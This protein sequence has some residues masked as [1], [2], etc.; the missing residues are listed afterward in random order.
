ME[1]RHDF[2]WRVHAQIPPRGVI[3][4]FNRSHYEDVLSP[5]VHHLI[6]K[7]VV[8][9]RLDRINDFED[10][11]VE[12]GVVILKF[13]LHISR[14]EQ[15]ERLQARIDTPD[16]HWKLS[17]ADFKERR[18]WPQYQNAY[19]EILSKTS[20]KHAPWFIIP[21]DHKW[22]RNIAISGIVLDVMKGLKLSYPKS[23]FDPRKVDLQGIDPH[24]SKRRRREKS[25]KPTADSFSKS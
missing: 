4:I 8:K 3:G 20:R 15:T 16:K 7:K 12:D 5:R 9:D 17:E 13:F 24:P 6:S 11:L 25:T 2:L 19:Q 1:V 23:T 22:F 14:G 18:F 10:G 21:S